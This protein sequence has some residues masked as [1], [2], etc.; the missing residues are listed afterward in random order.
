M[1]IS[2]SK[3]SKSMNFEGVTFNVLDNVEFTFNEGTIYAISGKSGAG[4]TTLLNIIGMLDKQSAGEVFYDKTNTNKM[5]SKKQVNFRRKNI[6]FIFQEYQLLDNITCLKN[7][8]IP[9]WLDKTMNEKKVKTISTHWLKRI[10]LENR[11][12]HYPTT[13]SGGE[14]QRTAIAR[15]LV[16]NPKVVLADEPTGNVDEESEQ[17]ILDIFRDLAKQGKTIIIVTHSKTVKDFADIAL[18]LE[19]GKLLTDENKSKI[20]I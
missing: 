11:I 13:L 15:A 17:I 5:L 8:Q 7:V 19:E 14:Q 9:L 12:N 3:I 16:N 20:S 1:N 6:G 10:G 18:K 4:K 2:L